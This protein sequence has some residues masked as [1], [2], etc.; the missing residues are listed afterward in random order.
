MKFAGRELTASGKLTQ[1]RLNWKPT[2]TGLIADL[3]AMKY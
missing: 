3:A 1:E 2:G